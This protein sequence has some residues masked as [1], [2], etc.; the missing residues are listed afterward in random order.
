MHQIRALL[1]VVKN[2]DMGVFKAFTLLLHLPPAFV[3]DQE[4][5]G[6]VDS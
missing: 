1:F 6:M 2:I 3:G 5:E 4:Q